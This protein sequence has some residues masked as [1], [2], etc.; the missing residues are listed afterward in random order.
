MVIVL[1]LLPKKRPHTH[2]F[3]EQRIVPHIIA[4]SDELHL[5]IIDNLERVS[6]ACLGVI[7]EGFMV[8]I[9]RSMELST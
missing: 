2:L 4:L 8:P 6:P 3:L 1:S 5:K 7:C 9:V